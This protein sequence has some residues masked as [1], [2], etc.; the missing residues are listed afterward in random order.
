MSRSAADDQ[1]KPVSREAKRRIAKV[2]LYMTF[3]LI[4]VA[5]YSVAIRNY[6]PVSPDMQ[7]L[8]EF[9]TGAICGGSILVGMYHLFMAANSD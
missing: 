8:L 7:A 3:A 2:W 5:C 1:Y 4:V 6:G 9:L